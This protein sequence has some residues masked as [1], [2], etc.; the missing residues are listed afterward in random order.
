MRFGLFLGH[1]EILLGMSRACMHYSWNHDLCPKDVCCCVRTN[2]TNV[3]IETPSSWGYLRR[4]SLEVLARDHSCKKS[5]KKS[6]KT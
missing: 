1:V 5:C 3:V 2:E 4:N 6:S